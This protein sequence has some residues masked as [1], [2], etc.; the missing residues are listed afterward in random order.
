MN[1]VFLD[2]LDHLMII[3]I[4]DILAYSRLENEYKEHLHIVLETLHR[5]CLY[6]KFS[7]CAFW[8]PSVG[9][10]G[11]IVSREG[12][13]VYPQKGEAIT[14]WERPKTVLEVHNF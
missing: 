2:Y 6:A 9:L 12:I 3:F 7:K 1:K 14:K 13:L 10:L 11:H 4:D 5:K 8:L